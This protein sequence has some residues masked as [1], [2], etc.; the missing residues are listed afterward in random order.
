MRKNALG[1]CSAVAA[2]AVAGA[3]E[4][5]SAGVWQTYRTGL[6]SG[7]TDW[8]YENFNDLA[9][10]MSGGALAQ[11]V[12]TN[13]DARAV[14]FAKEFAGTETLAGYGA[15]TT[16]IEVSGDALQRVI[17][18]PGDPNGVTGTTSGVALAWYMTYETGAG[19]SIFISKAANR[20]DLNSIRNGGAVTFTAELL[21]SNFE[22]FNNGG[23][24]LGLSFEQTKANA[25]S[26]GLLITSANAAGAT[27]FTGTPLIQY[28]YTWV[29]GTWDY[30]WDGSQWVW[31]E[32]VAG[33][34]DTDSIQRNGDYGA[35]STGTTTINIFNAAAVPGHGVAALISAA[36][37]VGARRRR[38]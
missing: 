10:T 16:S 22:S 26:F 28:N 21:A 18:D 32:V 2:V 1:V 19:T 33:Y 23:P 5:A 38:R 37:L 36:G 11:T 31:T 15:L 24:Q 30:V 35:Y 12:T 27:D 4:T 7:G 8:Q 13:M 20:L 34:W 25:Q 14:W 9:G 29:P 17:R 6:V 3:V